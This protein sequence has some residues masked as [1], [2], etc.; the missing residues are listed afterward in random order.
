MP[1]IG[2]ILSLVLRYDI[3]TIDRFASVQ[4]VVSDGRLVKCAKA[5]AGK[6]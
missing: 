3:H 6:R 5:S 4:D 1:G 2:K